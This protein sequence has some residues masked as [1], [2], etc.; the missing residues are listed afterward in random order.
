[1]SEDKELPKPLRGSACLLLHDP[2]G[3]AVRHALGGRGTP[4]SSIDI[5]V[6]RASSAAWG[7]IHGMCAALPRTL[8]DLRSYC[9]ADGAR[10]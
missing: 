6:E 1:M 4:G 2:S 9:R 3:F 5:G 10:V 8:N 7:I